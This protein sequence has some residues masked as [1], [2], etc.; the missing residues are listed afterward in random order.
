MELRVNSHV[1]LNGNQNP[2]RWLK[3]F[4]ISLMDLP[5]KYKVAYL[6]GKNEIMGLQVYNHI[7]SECE[8]SL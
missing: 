6:V 5:T 3:N 7:R 8:F 1:L 4:Y 2:T